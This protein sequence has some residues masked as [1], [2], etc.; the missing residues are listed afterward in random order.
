MSAFPETFEALYDT[1]GLPWKD[2]NFRSVWEPLK[3][4][5]LS[6]GLTLWRD[7]DPEWPGQL[8]PPDS[9]PRAP[10]GFHYRLL[11]DVDRN[12]SFCHC[13]P[14]MC[15]ARTTD[16]RDVMIKVVAMGDRGLNHKEALQRLASGNIASV[17]GN[18]T[19]P[20]LQWIERGST[21][22]A[23]L[24]YLSKDD[25]STVYLY[26]NTKD[27][28][29]HLLQMLEALEFCHSQLVVHCDVFEGNFLCNFTGASIHLDSCFQQPQPGQPVRPFR[30][31]FPYKL[32]L[33]DFE[34]AHC[35]D[36]DSDP[37]TRRL[38]GRPV[39][40]YCEN[41]EDGKKW[42]YDRPVAPEMDAGEPYDPFLTD[43]WQL[44]M[45]FWRIESANFSFH[46]A[47][48]NLRKRMTAEAPKDRPT[49]LEAL[50][51]LR[52]IKSRLSPDE[53]STTVWRDPRK[54]N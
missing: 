24:P 22:F 26:E 28:I 21:T 18:H 7:P 3:D 16:G 42:E 6:H 40:H 52:A 49:A 9:R 17:I 35:F 47:L 30:S 32:Y 19:V 13:R 27:L 8:R 23:V 1:M 48:I 39:V 36:P 4:F 51:E 15:P 38:S 20:V 14:T 53:L 50:T 44:G 29:D 2:R 46:D 34:W 54:A 5:F 12:D 33:I 41:E 31:L 43:V 10:D 45:Y 25:L 11:A 37:S